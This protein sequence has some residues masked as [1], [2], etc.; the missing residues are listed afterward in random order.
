[1][2]LNRYILD[3]YFDSVDGR[4][5]VDGFTILR[6]GWSGWHGF[7]EP[8]ADSEAA[9]P[10]GTANDADDTHDPETVED[11]DVDPSDE[12]DSS[13]ESEPGDEAEEESSDAALIESALSV[14]FAGDDVDAASM[15]VLRTLAERAVQRPKSFEEARSLY[16][17]LLTEGVTLGIPDVDAVAAVIEA[18]ESDDVD[19]APES[20]AAGEDDDVDAEVEAKA[21][22]S[23][24]Q[25]GQEDEVATS[26]TLP[27]DGGE[28]AP[29]WVRHI[30]GISWGLH[31]FAPELFVPYLFRTKFHQFEA[32]C[33]ELEIAMPRLPGK[34]SAPERAMY[35]FE[36]NA[37]LQD[38]RAE[39]GMTPDEL[40]AFLYGFATR[41]VP[42]EE[43]DPLPEPARAWLLLGSPDDA[44]WLDAAGDDSRSHWQGGYDIRPGDICV[45]WCRSPRSYVHSVWR[46]TSSG[47]ADPFFYYYRTVWIARPLKVPPITFAE[48][49]A[50]PVWSQKPAVRAHFQNS[51]GKEIT[52]Q[53]YDA[54][55][56]MF[57][58]KGFDTGPLPK[59][60]E[61]SLGLDPTEL[62]RE[63]D[64]EEK[65]LEP[66]LEKLGLKKRDWRRQVPLRMGR[67]IR[68]YPDY[69]LGLRGDRGDESARA[70]IEAKLRISGP[71][72]LD[73]AFSQAASYAARLRAEVLCLCAAEG[74][75]LYRRENGRFRRSTVKE[76]RWSDVGEPAVLRELGELLR[77]TEGGNR[78]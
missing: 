1:M 46:A 18:L 41:A 19:E 12:P 5:L 64:V 6:V 50:D 11:D 16:E 63:S 66:L 33:A 24:V 45:M 57:E 55:L 23:E 73:E 52:R 49:Q 32:I 67:G 42:I 9:T 31:C 43:V 71:R 3:L 44:P 8:E 38:F 70:I 36:L 28:S 59:L 34:A 47:F 30:A 14:L 65:L 61:V 75:W 22:P 7:V 40:N 26:P 68:V 13:D 20:E 17:R 58:S 15:A 27:M 21:E 77:L 54:L 48:I 2:R 39:H 53:E 51:S 10:S 78:R 74:L 56:R 4:D 25:E 69:V 35:Y 37:V 76:V 29:D 72:D 60:Q 62:E